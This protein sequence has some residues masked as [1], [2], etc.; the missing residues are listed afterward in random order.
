MFGLGL[1]VDGSLRRTRGGFCVDKDFAGYFC[2]GH[3]L[4]ICLFGEIGGNFS[5]V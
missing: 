5:R 4:A 3:P 2:I 1:F